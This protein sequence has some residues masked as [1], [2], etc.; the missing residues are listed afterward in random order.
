ML[1]Y[2]NQTHGHRITQCNHQVPAISALLQLYSDTIAAQGSA[3]GNC[4][5]FV[6]GTVHPICRLAEHQRGAIHAKKKMFNYT[7]VYSLFS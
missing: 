6:D 7:R 1:D 2:I 4:F 5:G 3:L